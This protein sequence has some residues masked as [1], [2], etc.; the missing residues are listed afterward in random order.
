MVRPKTFLTLVIS[1]LFWCVFDPIAAVSETK[2]STE[3]HPNFGTTDDVFIFSVVV[4]NPPDEDAKPLITGGKDFDLALIG[5]SK[6]VTIIN[7]KLNRSITYNYQLTPRREGILET[8]GAE[9]V[10][11]ATKLTAPPLPVT[12][13]G[14][15]RQDEIQEGNESKEYFIRQGFDGP[16][17]VYLGQQLTHLIEIYTRSSL[18]DPQLGDLK[19]PGF[20]NEPFGQQENSRKFINGVPFTVSA[21]KRALYPQSAGRIEILPRELKAKVRTRGQ[22]LPSP[23]GGLDPFSS[24]IFDDFFGRAPLRPIK[25][26][27]NPLEVAVT[28]TPPIPQDLPLL[29]MLS[30]PVGKTEIMT[31]YDPSDIKF[32]EAK[33]ITVTV[34]SSGLVNSLKG[35]LFSS[36]PALKVYEESPQTSLEN[37]GSRMVYRKSFKISLL[38]MSGEKVDLAP[39]RLGFFDPE[40]GNYAIAEGQPIR[41]LV[42]G[43]PSRSYLKPD[44]THNAPET[45]EP[46]TGASSTPEPLR[47]QEPTLTEWLK[48]R[49]SPALLAWILV[50]ALSTIAAIFFGLYLRRPGLK[51]RD[52]L[53]RVYA[54]DS[55]SSLS[56]AIKAAIRFRYPTL[57]E[58]FTRSEL[59]ATVS[60]RNLL[61]KLET[62]LDG[63]EE[64]LYGRSPRPLAELKS[65]SVQ[66]FELLG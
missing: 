28:P 45:A 36:T 6:R 30:P 37:D 56:E 13:K 54:A 7:S 41:F 49:S 42:S 20:H 62:L 57:S 4:Q 53:R 40:A 10:T 29:G 2:L 38:P 9:L 52:L 24:D 43:A 11:A 26:I 44:P 64:A 22:A 23:F 18:I 48:E 58:D 5:P 46:Q 33:T 65:L 8:P 12:I 34:S 61:Y 66:C 47:Y 3:I 17:Q 15:R 35:P 14:T 55:A 27:S 60:D 31:D 39:L 19:I 50:G 59:R 25:L 51:R 63:F 32:G 16:N 1:L 21:L